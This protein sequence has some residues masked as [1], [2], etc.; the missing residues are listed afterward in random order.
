[1]SSFSA[2]QEV[3]VLDKATKPTLKEESLLPKL[4]YAKKLIKAGSSK[5]TE[6]IPTL[7]FDVTFALPLTWTQLNVH[8]PDIFLFLLV[9]QTSQI[10]MQV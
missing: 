3:V 2:N 7:V 1:M 8:S 9:Q 6:I 4:L 10:Q 5:K